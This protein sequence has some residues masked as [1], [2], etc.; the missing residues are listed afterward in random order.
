MSIKDDL[1]FLSR[2]ALDLALM[3]FLGDKT[4]EAKGIDAFLV[5]C[6]VLREWEAGL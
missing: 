5:L 2:Q 6:L 1:L 4:G 3:F